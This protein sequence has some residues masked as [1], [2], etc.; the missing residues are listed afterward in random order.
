M[1]A[2]TFPFRVGKVDAKATMLVELNPSTHPS[3]VQ[4]SST[5]V[6]AATPESGRPFRIAR[7]RLAMATWQRRC[8]GCTDE[9]KSS[10]QRVRM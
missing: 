9:L 6:A 2:N 3:P 1:E 5:L 10:R 7:F 8:L 4:A